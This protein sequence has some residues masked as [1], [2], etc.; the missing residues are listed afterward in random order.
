MG[1]LSRNLNVFE[2]ARSYNFI[3]VRITI[4][5]IYLDQMFDVTSMVMTNPV[6]DGWADGCNV[7]GV[8]DGAVEGAKVGDEVMKTDCDSMSHSFSMDDSNEAIEASTSSVLVV[9]TIRFTCA[10]TPYSGTIVN[11]KHKLL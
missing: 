2:T 3:H 11:S 8:E 7:V 5:P 10:L 4:K 9:S 6:I 1:N